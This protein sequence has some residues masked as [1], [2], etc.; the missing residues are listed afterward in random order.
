MGHWGF[1]SWLCLDLPIQ[2]PCA[3]PGDQLHGGGVV[4]IQEG[5]SAPTV[6]YLWGTNPKM[7]ATCADG[8][9]GHWAL[10]GHSVP[11]GY[12]PTSF[13]NCAY[14][15]RRSRP[16][17]TILISGTR[18]NSMSDLP[19]N[20]EKGEVN[21]EN[22][23]ADL[24]LDEVSLSEYNTGA[25]Q[26]V[27]SEKVET[28]WGTL[29]VKEVNSKKTKTGLGTC[30]EKVVNSVKMKVG[31]GTLTGAEAAEL[32]TVVDLTRVEPG[33]AKAGPGDPWTWTPRKRRS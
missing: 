15:N 2:C 4:E 29:T 33:M 8:M 3:R 5:I 11:E 6:S 27:D 19:K 14:H 1:V 17:R 22:E 21:Q 16:R 26:V 9:H 10:N 13:S 18:G 32:R 12:Q 30:S 20:G 23:M 31:L 28:E 24:V 25:G 7:E